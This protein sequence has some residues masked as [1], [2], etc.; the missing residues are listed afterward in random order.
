MCDVDSEHLAKSAEEVEKLQGSRPQ[1]F[2]H[3]EDLLK[4]PG[5]EAVII[6][7][8]PHWHALPVHRRARRRDWMSIA[9]NRWPTTSAK[10]GRWWRRAKKSDRIVQIGFQ[11]RQGR[12][13]PA[14]PRLHP[15]GQ[16]RPH[17]PGRRPDPLHRRHA[18][19][20]RRRTRP[21]RWTGTCG[22]APRPR[23]PTA[24][25]SAT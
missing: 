7:T 25:R 15:G 6:A 12:R 13:H 16:R 24:R 21:P 17:R 8:P 3:Y 9:R 4:T 2:K 11:R 10:A 19:T 5:L 20:P 22:A 18:R 14:G 1:T 23:S